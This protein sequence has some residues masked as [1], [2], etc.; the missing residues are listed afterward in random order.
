MKLIKLQLDNFKSFGKVELNFENLAESILITGDNRDTVGADSN[1]S[2]KSNLLDSIP[3]ILMGEVPQRILSDSVIRRDANVC[4]G[5]LLLLDDKHNY[6]VFRRRSK[7]MHKLEFFIDGN[8]ETLRK[9]ADT[10]QLILSTFGLPTKTSTAFTDFFNCVYFSPGIVDAFASHSM[11][12]SKRLEL[13]SRFLKLHRIDTA[14]LRVKMALVEHESEM[15]QSTAKIEL[16]QERIKET[17]EENIEEELD[18]LI[19]QRKIKLRQK[20][21][22]SKGKGLLE[23]QEKKKSRI[24]FSKEI[25]DNLR[26]QAI[27]LKSEVDKFRENKEIYAA[28]KLRVVGLKKKVVDEDKAAMAISEAESELA[29]IEIYIDS[30]DTGEVTKDADCPKCGVELLISETD[31]AIFDSKSEKERMENREKEI[32]RSGIKR[33][34]LSGRIKKLEELVNGRKIRDEYEELQI[35]IQVLEKGLDNDIFD[36]LESDFKEIDFKGRLEKEKL[37]RDLIEFREQESKLKGAVV[38]DLDEILY[39]IQVLDDELVQLN[40]DIGRLEQHK[41]FLK[42]NKKQLLIY[43]KSIKLR[44]KENRKY[45]IWKEAFPRIKRI[46]INSFLPRFEDE[47]NRYLKL[48]DAGVEVSFDI[49]FNRTNNEFSI[50]VLE[51]CEEWSFDERSR[52]MCTR[53]ALCIGLALGELAKFD[54]TVTFDF[55][56]FDEVLDSLDNIGIECFLRMIEYLPGQKFFI[57]HDSNLKNQFLVDSILQVVKENGVSRIKSGG[58]RK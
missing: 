49:D 42:E 7:S 21:E 56:L 38:N 45:L 58:V 31:L 22:W 48:L 24:E 36:K 28:S 2:G 32:R 17:E 47:T 30:I 13:I 57:S 29:D 6:E 37:D 35:E 54:R 55:R 25:R 12:S 15:K 39:R 43:S 41:E 44:E 3:W 14:L 10:Q 19:L 23:L 11:T 20:D 8:D 16:L 9:I 53:I 27:D 5:R 40:M 50:S 4:E 52:G 1:E 26:K 34:L 18:D 33:R 51:G 46:I